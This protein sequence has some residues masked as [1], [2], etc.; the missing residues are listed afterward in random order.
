M[1]PF[2]GEYYV[3]KDGRYGW[4]VRSYHNKKI[5]ATDGSQGYEHSVDCCDMFHSLFPVLELKRV[6]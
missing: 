3:R 4:R 6:R 2:Y 1:N 5:V